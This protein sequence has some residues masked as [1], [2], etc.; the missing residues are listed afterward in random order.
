MFLEDENSEARPWFHTFFQRGRMALVG[1]VAC[2]AML[3]ALAATAH[4]ASPPQPM[5]SAAAVE[6]RALS[7]GEQQHVAP[8]IAVDPMP[9]ASTPL[10]APLIPSS[11]GT[12]ILPSTET[13]SDRY[14]LLGLM[15]LCFAA[16][17]AFSLA[18]WRRSLKEMLRTLPSRHDV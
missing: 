4:A 6:E 11:S 2:T 13:L 14:I 5:T 7:A 17:T 8:Q 1:M 18:L 9:T 16:M 15:M 3:T 12:L 10:V